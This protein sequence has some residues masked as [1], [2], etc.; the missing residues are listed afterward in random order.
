[1]LQSTA[2]A[3]GAAAL[4][5]GAVETPLTAT[6]DAEAAVFTAGVLLGAGAAVGLG[7]VGGMALQRWKSEDVE[8]NEDDLS[9]DRMTQ[10][11]EVATLIN[12][13]FDDYRTISDNEFDP[14]YNSTSNTFNDA[15]WSELRTTA[16]RGIQEDWSPAKAKRRAGQKVDKQ[17]T[18]FFLNHIQLWNRRVEAFYPY[19]ADDINDSNKDTIFTENEYQ[20]D[21]AIRND[22]IDPSSVSKWEGVSVD[23]NLVGI[24]T[25]AFDLPWD[26]TKFEKWDRE[27]VAVY[28]PWNLRPPLPDKF[29]EDGVDSPGLKGK[30]K[31]KHDDY[32]TIKPYR[33][34]RGFGKYLNK[35]AS[36]HTQIKSDLNTYIDT[37]YDAVSQGAVSEIQ[38]LSPRDLVQEF[39]GANEMERETAEL[40]AAGLY[41][42][43]EAGGVM[44]KVTHPDLTAESLWGRLFVRF[45]DGDEKTIE[46]GTKI[47]EY[48]YQ[49][50]YLIY[51]DRTSNEPETA[52]LDGSHTLEVLDVSGEGVDQ[53]ENVDKNT[54]EDGTVPIWNPEQDGETPAWIKKPPAGETIVVETEKGSYYFDPE[55]IKQ[56]DDGTYVIPDTQISPGER[57]KKIRAVGR[58]DYVQPIDNVPDPTTVDQA[59]LTDRYDN[60]SYFRDKVREETTRGGGGVGG[61]WINEIIGFF[62]G[63]KNAVI[64]AVVAVV[65]ASVVGALRG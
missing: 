31:V 50:A 41:S 53:G 5:T 17:A 45:R 42:P 49:M 7:V 21:T 57:I 63:I 8:I 36:D 47:E 44:A 40:A 33:Y 16:V 59:R 12:D 15:A 46:P 38:A 52:L 26:P 43:K 20:E 25:T 65:G 62:G 13:G 55:S 32:E 1:M 39:A 51:Q 35:M 3:G 60:I 64:A 34:N 2:A 29:L 27:D 61:D 6:Q 56:R 58:L 23:D 11:Y 28:V 9:D 48:E 10:T 22:S 19:M 24:K 4:G 30:I 14:Q 18:R 54:E 37:V